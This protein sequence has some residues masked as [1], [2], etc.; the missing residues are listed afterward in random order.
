MPFKSLP[1]AIFSLGLVF[2]PLAEANKD[3]K[4]EVPKNEDYSTLDPGVAFNTSDL[5]GS[6][7]KMTLAQK[8]LK[9]K[10]AVQG[11]C[12]D[13]IHEALLQSNSNP[14]P[15]EPGASGP[16]SGTL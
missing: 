7:T 4:A 14:D 2:S 9:E 11:A 5:T 1:I 6:D 12:L 10:G 3:P 8:A 13:C 16:S 15:N